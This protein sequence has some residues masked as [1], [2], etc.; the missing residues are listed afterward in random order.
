MLDYVVTSYIYFKYLRLITRLITYLWSTFVN[1]EWYTQSAV[2]ASLHEHILHASPD[3]Q[4][5][6]CYTVEN[7]EKLDI[8]STFGW[9]SATTFPIVVGDVEGPLLVR[10]LL[11]LGLKKILNTFLN[12]GPLVVCASPS[13]G[14]INTTLKVR[15]D[16]KCSWSIFILVL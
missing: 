15:D 8:V 2:K 3:L 12:K 11:I 13:F 9:E 1:N 7:F 6:I 10:S 16:P 4:R 14:E 5:Q